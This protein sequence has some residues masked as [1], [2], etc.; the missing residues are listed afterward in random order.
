MLE[1]GSVLQTWRLAA[2]PIIG[3]VTSAEPIGDH[4]LAY[5]EY[6]GTVSGGRGTVKRYD[7]GEYAIISD[8][9][10]SVKLQLQ[11]QRLNGVIAVIDYTEK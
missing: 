1:T 11:G 5:L 9:S 6:E 4:R 7:T 10:R 3:G 2:L 8:D